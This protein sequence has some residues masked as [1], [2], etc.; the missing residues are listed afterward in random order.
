MNAAAS[1]MIQATYGDLGSAGH[2]SS[3]P[4]Y[5]RPALPS[6][7]MIPAFGHCGGRALEPGSV[8]GLPARLRRAPQERCQPARRA[9]IARYEPWRAHRRAG[10]RSRAVRCLGPG[11]V[12]KLRQR[13]LPPRRQQHQCA[14]ACITCNIHPV[15][16][17]QL[18]KLSRRPRT[19]QPTTSNSVSGSV[20]GEA[21]AVTRRVLP[22]RLQGLPVG[23][24]AFNPHCH[25]RFR[26][27]H[28]TQ[29]KRL[30]LAYNLRFEFDRAMT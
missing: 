5:T 15:I 18:G 13:P 24:R 1:A 17:K 16:R 4:S 20:S 22:S 26:I 3:L 19:G 27:G 21:A 14:G 28:L 30:R 23:H 8:R 25:S 29:R 6:A 2:R 11:P 12:S 10:R 7:D 9:G